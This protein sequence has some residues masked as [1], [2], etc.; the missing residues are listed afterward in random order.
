MGFDVKNT[1]RIKIW[2]LFCPHTCRGCGRLGWVVCECCKNDI[3]AEWKNICPICKSTLDD[4]RQKCL[5]CK[6]EFDELYVGGYRDGILARMIKDFKY[7][8]VRAL[9]GDLVGI[10]DQMLPEKFGYNLAG[11]NSCDK[12]RVIIVPLPTISKHVR[13]RGFDHTWILGRSLA[14]KRKWGCKRLLD[15]KVDTVQVGST[16]DKRR[17]QAKEAYVLSGKIETDAI[18]L[19]L[20]DIWT[21]GATMQTGARLLREAGAKYVVGAILATGEPKVPNPEEDRGEKKEG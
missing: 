9:K 2:D 11:S 4:C 5:N 20:D 3:L 19:L 13:E 17:K 8:S 14:R 18:Y 16:A 1:T 21:T 15:R 7:H 10:F 6:N 12:Q